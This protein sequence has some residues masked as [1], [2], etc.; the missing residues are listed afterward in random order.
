MTNATDATPEPPFTILLR[1]IRGFQVSRMI[2]VAAKLGIADLLVDG[3]KTAEELAAATTTHAP[4]L[5]RLLR[6][7]ASLGIFAEDEQGRFALTPM[8]ELLQTGTATSLR[9]T[10]LYLGSPIF[11][12]VWGELPHGIITGE[13]G[14]RH[15]F[16]MNDWAYREQNPED[17]QGFN[18]FMTEVT[19]PDAAA[20]AA[21]YDF[22]SLKQ[23]VDVAGGQGTLIAA[24]LKANPNLRGILFDQPHV[25]TGAQPV[26][27]AA[28][29]ADRCEMVGGD[30][31]VELPAG[32]DGYI[33]KSIIHDWNDADSILILQNCRRAIQPAGKLLLVE[34][35]IPPGNTPH[36]GKLS[37]INMLIAPGGRE[38][39]EAEYGSLLAEAGFRLTQV[40]PLQ[41]SRSIIEAVPI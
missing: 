13:D 14:Y 27:E 32:A 5:Y 7:L 21:G 34:F 6:A 36:L 20:V 38:R 30:F 29:V 37:D 18:N 28:G 19:R 4:S 11:Q 40:L 9:D 41:T 12:R 3:A 16:G 33:L 26:L 1:M 8:A 2:Y 23:L 10:T 24:I 17:N 31:F 25:V 15:L 22:S 35:V 39:T